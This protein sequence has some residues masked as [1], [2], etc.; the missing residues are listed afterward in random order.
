MISYVRLSKVV[1]GA[2]LS[3][4]YAA[5]IETGGVESRLYPKAFLD[6]SL[7]V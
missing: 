7:K 5:K 1:G 6:Y 4:Y 2:G 3:G